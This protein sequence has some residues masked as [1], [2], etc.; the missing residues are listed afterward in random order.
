MLAYLD[1]IDPES[2]RI[3]RERYGC[4]AP[5][6]SD[7]V[8]YGRMALSR[9]YAVCE[10]PVTEALL[11]LLDK[12]LDYLVKDG[13]AFFDA[14]QNARIVTAAEQYYRVMYYGDAV[15]WNLRDQHMFDTLER[16]LAH[17]GPKSKAVVW[18]H[19]SHIGDAEFTEM[20]QVR[21]E[22]NIGQL[23]RARFGEDCALIGFGTDRGTVAAASDWD[24]PMEI[25]RVRPARDDSYEGRSRDADIPAFFLE[26]GPGQ[27]EHV[28]AALAEPLLERAIGVIYRPETE[29]LSHYF[30]AEL[31]RQF[32]AWIWF[33]ET[34]AV[35]ARA[36]AHPHGPDETYPSGL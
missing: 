19:N 1:K 5:W 26:T 2:A 34:R 32:D 14:E 11:D 25:K 10:R 18:A 27:K 12:R 28:R 24:G 36:E 20:G 8:R 15:S 29:L 31:S 30:Q 16:L 9:G 3:A 17:R 7:P 23:A 22:H 35:A 33:T 4:L 21:G 13:A 6:R